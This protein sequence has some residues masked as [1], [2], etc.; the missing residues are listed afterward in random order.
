MFEKFDLHP[1]TR[2]EYRIRTLHGAIVSVIAMVAA[3]ILFYS[4][5]N[6]SMT[7]EVVDHLFVNSSSGQALPISFNITFPSV[8]CELISVDVED[9]SGKSQE[10]VT[11]SIFKLDVDTKGR[12]V[13]KLK[14]HGDLGDTLNSEDDLVNHDAVKSKKFV[15]HH[16]RKESVADDAECGDCYGAG[17]EN[18]CCNTCTDVKAAYGRKGWRFDTKGIPQCANEAVMK[19]MENV[20]M[21]GGCNMNGLLQVPMGQGNLHFAMSSTAAHYHVMEAFT[22]ADLMASAYEAF[23]ITHTVHEFSIGEK[24]PGIKNPLDGRAKRI[25]DGHGIYQY[26]LKVVPTVYTYLNQSELNSNQYSVTEHLRQVV[27]GSS[28]GL[29]GVYFYYEM[30]PI[31]AHF[32]ERRPGFFQFLTSACAIIGGIF[33]VMGLFDALIYQLLSGKQEVIKS[34]KGLHKN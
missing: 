1:K 6:Y 20:D 33:T 21:S 2:D 13:G 28:R 7:T 24:F 5:L 11:H 17:E 23:N 9:A 4:E 10:D 19:T 27:I 30:S 26:Y 16:G 29:P 12:P 31:Q 14:K 8:P 25:E 18:E 22:F 3:V 15:V 34:N 32:E